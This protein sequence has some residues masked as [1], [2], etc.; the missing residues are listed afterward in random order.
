MKEK[1]RES[2]II[3]RGF[4]RGPAGRGERME[5]ERQTGWKESMDLPVHVT[6]EKL[7]FFTNRPPLILGHHQL[8]APSRLPPQLAPRAIPAL[9]FPINLPSFSSVFTFGAYLFLGFFNP[10]PFYPH[11]RGVFKALVRVP[12]DLSFERSLP[13]SAR[14]TFRRGF[15]FFLSFSVRVLS[16]PR[17]VIRHWSRTVCFSLIGMGFAN[18]CSVFDPA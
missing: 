15:S 18:R 14:A 13:A 6:C 5:M 2:P 17:L 16:V 12:I 10:L 1:D 11:L 4:L 9:R 8:P 3:L 7:L